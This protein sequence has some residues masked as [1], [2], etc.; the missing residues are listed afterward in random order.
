MISIGKL[1]SYKTLVAWGGLLLISLT[2]FLLILNPFARHIAESRTQISLSRERIESL[3]D[4]ISRFESETD[5]KNE[6]LRTRSIDLRTIGTT[7]DAEIVLSQAHEILTGTEPPTPNQ[8]NPFNQ[9]AGPTKD[10]VFVQIKIHLAIPWPEAVARIEAALNKHPHL[11]VSEARLTSGPAKT[12][13]VQLTL[14][15]LARAS[16]PTPDEEPANGPS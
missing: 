5:Q 13:N 6:L 4:R 16:A 11:L 14:E 8:N 10:L 3:R 15:L 9:S 7:E 12:V 2:I 1:D